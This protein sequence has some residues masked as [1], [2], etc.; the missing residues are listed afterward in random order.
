MQTG[1]LRELRHLNL[2]SVSAY[3]DGDEGPGEQ[4]TV[5]LS[6]ALRAGCCP[7]LKHLNLADMEM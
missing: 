5:A 3:E 2:S 7:M 4:G 6:E 1:H